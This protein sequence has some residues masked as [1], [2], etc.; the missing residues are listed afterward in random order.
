MRVARDI[1][2]DSGRALRRTVTR[3]RMLA[4]D[5]DLVVEQHRPLGIGL[6]RQ[7]RDDLDRARRQLEPQLARRVLE[8]RSQLHELG[9]ERAQAAVRPAAAPPPAGPSRASPTARPGAGSSRTWMYAYG[10]SPAAGKNHDS[11][12]RPSRTPSIR[13]APCA[14][15]TSRSPRP[16]RPAAVAPSRAARRARPGAGRPSRRRRRR[17]RRR[18]GPRSASSCSAGTRS[19][20]ICARHACDERLVG[21]PEAQL[22]PAAPATARRDRGVRVRDQLGHDLHEVDAALGEVLAEVAPAHRADADRG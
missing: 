18:S 5:R 17:R 10:S 15:Q 19:A 8:H 16:N 4:R 1:P 21:R 2:G 7:A 13:P 20:R 9:D 12:A 3:A 11:T 14:S 6:G 22:D